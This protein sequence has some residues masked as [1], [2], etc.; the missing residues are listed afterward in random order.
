MI[1]RA[2]TAKFPARRGN[3]S[4][5]ASGGIPASPGFLSLS[6]QGS[7][8]GPHV[9]QASHDR[10]HRNG[11]ITSPRADMAWR[12]LAWPV[13]EGRS[14]LGIAVPVPV[15]VRIVVLAGTVALWNSSRFGIQSCAD[16]PPFRVSISGRPVT[17]L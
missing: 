1:M 16:R 13:Q 9:R 12:G 10:D 4:G 17:L 5:T 11:T 15:A 7:L 14:L 6:C 2:T 3:R 8:R